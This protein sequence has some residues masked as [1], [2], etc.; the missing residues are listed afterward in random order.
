[1][2]ATRTPALEIGARLRR[3]RKAAGLSQQALAEPAYTHAYVSTIEAGRRVPSRKA[4]EHFAAR[5]GVDPEELLTGRPTH[6]ETQLEQELQEAK[7]L[8]TSGALDEAEQK[9]ERVHREATRY[10]ATRVA[11]AAY[12]GLALVAERRGE[13][14]QAIQLLESSEEL[15][16]T[17]SPVLK[18][19]AVVAKARCFHNLGDL[20]YAI[21]LLESL[22][23]RLEQ[24]ELHDP[25]ALLKVQAALVLPYF[26]SGLYKKAA[27][28]ASEALSL[29]PRV[30]DPAKIAMMYVNVARVL[31]HQ[32][33]VAEAEASL[34]RARDLYATLDLQLETAIAHLARG[35]L[36]SRDGDFLAAAQELGRA[37][38]V[39][40]RLG[41]DLNLAYALNELGRVLRLQGRDSEAAAMLDRSLSLLKDGTDTAAL[42]RAHRELGLLRLDS[43]SVVAEKHLRE[44][45]D[46][47]RR[48]EEPVEFAATLRILGDLKTSQGQAQAGCEMYREGILALENRL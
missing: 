9:Y 48:S 45:A 28:V 1:M 4:L 39:F 38:D 27:A 3:L 40:Q 15:L 8:P 20:R 13:L 25:G 29:A 35:F 37:A 21:Y 23:E 33:H 2:L 12:E 30:D 47:F 22:L 17:E 10:E 32:G 14:V 6:L 46:L 41:N 7:A 18:V 36:L 5:L 34:V 44:A 24:S 19:D 31:L 43:D 26:D 16:R 11:A 42:A